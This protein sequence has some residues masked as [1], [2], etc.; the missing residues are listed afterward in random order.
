MNDIKWALNNIQNVLFFFTSLGIGTIR[1]IY[2]GLFFPDLLQ[3]I[4]LIFI[5]LFQIIS[6][7]EIIIL[8]NCLVIM[9]MHVIHSFAKVLFIFKKGPLEQFRT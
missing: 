9:M 7:K 2:F 3:L 6:R 8:E 1:I 4:N 5:I